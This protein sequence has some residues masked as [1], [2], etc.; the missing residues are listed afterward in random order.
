MRARKGINKNTVGIFKSL[1]EPPSLFELVTQQGNFRNG[2]S[3][4]ASH[5]PIFVME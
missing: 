1:N 5:A 3:V 2:I 4:R